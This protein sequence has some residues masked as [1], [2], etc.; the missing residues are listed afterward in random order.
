LSGTAEERLGGRYRLLAPIGTGGMAVVWRARDEVL[1]REVAVK[2]LSVD[3]AADPASRD[4]I[5]AE[6]QAVARLSHPNITAVHDYGESPVDGTRYVV[7]ELLAGDL[8]STRLRAAPMSWRLATQI[9]AQVAAALA[10]AHERGVVHRDIKPTNVMLTPAGAKV[11]DFGVAGLAGSPDEDDAPFF[12]TPAYL[13]PERLLGGI[14]V[15]ATDVY[16]LGLL[17]YR[18]LTDRLPWD[19]ETPTQMIANHVYEPP[20]PLPAIDGLPEDVGRLV[21][22]CLA[23]EPADRP[24]AYEAARVLAAATGIPVVLPGDDAASTQ[25][26]LSAPA[27]AITRRRRRIVLALAAGVTA[28]GLALAAF[29][30]FRPDGSPS[31]AACR[32]NFFI[33]PEGN[34]I[35]NARLTVVNTGDVPARPWHVAFTWPTGEK[36][37]SSHGARFE[38]SGVEVRVIGDQP[39]PAGKA[40]TA[41]L[42]GEAGPQPGPPSD[43]ALNG[44]GC[45]TRMSGDGYLP[46]LTG[47]TDPPADFD[48]PRPPLMP[49]PGPHKPP[50]S[51][52][53]GSTLGTQPPAAPRGS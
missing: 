50:R 2:L 15:P 47:V 38:Q 31:P 52:P 13:A 23:K 32:I 39:L 12:G 10:A 29:V 46:P 41:G 9:G 26:V 7:M 53:P 45:D 34:R 8:L 22:R 35:W 36:V 25:E 21:G 48:S 17:V 37:T 19:A 51:A 14:V 30:W 6:A 24:T 27:P 1:G 18:C 16:A 11:L 20:N 3:L 4:R 5:R 49:P 33:R 43:F 40:V 28:I 42:V 44:T